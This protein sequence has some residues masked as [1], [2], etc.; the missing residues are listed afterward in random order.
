M[1]RDKAL[2]EIDGTPM[3]RRV[4]DALEAA[5]ASA[6]FAVGGDVRALE[7]IGLEVRP[8]RVAGAGPLVATLTALEA[9]SH[10]HVLVVACDLLRPSPAAMA[11][12]VRQLVE[13]PGAVGAVPVVDGHRQWV[14]A[15][16]HRRVASLLRAAV[17][18]GQG[19]LRAVGADLL[20]VELDDIRPGD[21]ADADEPADLPR[22]LRKR[23]GGR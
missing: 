21:L 8:D 7:A 6:V 15:A 19:S 9:A 3:A 14:H 22:S 5:G 23:S 1:G 4:A 11:A 10:D 20:V 2:I 16:W 13:H 12:T 18:A 17:D